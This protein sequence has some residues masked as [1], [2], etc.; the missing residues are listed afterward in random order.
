M[1]SND[2]NN[3][4]LRESLEELHL[5]LISLPPTEGP[6][7]EKRDALAAHIREAL[8]SG[9]LEEMHISLGDVLNEEVVSFQEAHPRLASLMVGIRD[10]LSSIGI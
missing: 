7:Q 10:L 4:Q 8:D 3:E 1:Q 6:E 9:N 5:E 2:S